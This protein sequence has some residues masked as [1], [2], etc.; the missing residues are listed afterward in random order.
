MI[1][2]SK[3]SARYI[4]AYVGGVTEAASTVVT[5]LKG[6]VRGMIIGEE[7]FHLSEMASTVGND[8]CT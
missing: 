1:P 2:R 8:T 3:G 7:V 6:C 5:P 4:R